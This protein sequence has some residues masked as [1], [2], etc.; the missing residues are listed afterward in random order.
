MV[1]TWFY[2][3]VCVA[4]IG[5]AGT[6]L[7]HYGDAISDKTGIGGSWI[8]VLLLAT[9]TSLPEL[10]T[11]ISSV[12]LAN[13]PDVAA[14]DI[15]GSCA[16]NLL[17][18]VFLDY[19]DRDTPFFKYAGTG[20]IL[21]AGFGV[22]MLGFVSWY[23]VLSQ[24]G[25]QWSIWNIG[26]YSPM[27]LLIYVLAMRIIF[28]YEKA[29]TAEFT[30]KEPDKYPGQSL[31]ELI[32]RY[33]VAAAFVVAAGVWLPY[34]AADIAEQMGWSHTF[35]GTMFAAL[36]TSLP[37][38]VVT[39]TAVRIGA[40]DMAIGDLLGSNLFNI[41]IL[42][43][44][45]VFYR[46]GDLISSISPVH[47]ISAISAMLMTGIAIIGLY[48]RSSRQILNRFGWPSV[49]LLI[50]YLAN[51]GMLYF[52]SNS[53]SDRGGAEKVPAAYNSAQPST[54]ASWLG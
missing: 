37:E 28:V 30:G 12:A 31:R 11:G 14:G 53:E 4:T 34:I 18:L 47:L 32:I 9:V 2:F 29:Q 51:A 40:V 15:F 49:F 38:L 45:D 23:L 27:I 44:D 33:C 8:G 26:I 20:H 10:A 50:V 42:S 1:T 16:Y 7:T 35:V 19:L 13:V 25:L 21:S 36:V 17:I 5:I 3:L 52:Y 41:L 46:T 43:I 48:F 6:K 54:A 39:Y 24:F 22:V